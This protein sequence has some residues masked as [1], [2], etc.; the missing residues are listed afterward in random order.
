MNEDIRATEALASIQL[1]QDKKY[2]RIAE[3]HLSAVQALDLQ[4]IGKT[5]HPDVQVITPAGEVHNKD[6]FLAVYHKLFSQADQVQATLQSQ[7]RDQS[8]SIYNVI[9]AAGAVPITN[10]MTHDEELGLIKKIEMVYDAVRLQNY[11][12]QPK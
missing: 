9:F 5:L 8:K 12:K 3:A 10:V 7:L 6:S 1:A 2:T 11:L 4:A